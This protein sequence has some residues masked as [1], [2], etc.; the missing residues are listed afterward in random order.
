MKKR[1]QLCDL[2]DSCQTMDQWFWAKV[3]NRFVCKIVMVTFR[4]SPNE[5]FGWFRKPT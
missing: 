3:E 5:R 2:M 4:D 1:M